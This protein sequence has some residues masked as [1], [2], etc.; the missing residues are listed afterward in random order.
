LNLN[1]NATVD[2]DVQIYERTSHVRRADPLDRLFL[3]ARLTVS[4]QL[5]CEP[6]TEIVKVHGWG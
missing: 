5:C 4:S 6:I 3:V 1:V 2:A